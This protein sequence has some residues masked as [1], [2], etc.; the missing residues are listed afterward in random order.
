MYLE[1]QKVTTLQ[2]AAVRSDD[3][4]LTH[5]SSFRKTRQCDKQRTSNDTGRCHLILL[6]G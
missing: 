1:E 4:S 6:G 3:Y 2:Q 5:R